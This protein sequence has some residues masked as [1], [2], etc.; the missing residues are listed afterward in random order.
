MNPRSVTFIELTLLEG[1]CCDTS[2]D[3]SAAFVPLLDEHL[4]TFIAFFY[5]P[6]N[7]VSGVISHLVSQQI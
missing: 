7:P 6:L 1:K 5:C 3:S 2:W 4:F